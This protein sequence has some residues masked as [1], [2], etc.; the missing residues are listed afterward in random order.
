MSKCCPPAI[1][2]FM[3]RETCLAGNSDCFDKGQSCLHRSLWGCS[4]FLIAICPLT[5][6]LI[7]LPSQIPVFPSEFPSLPGEAA[8]RDW[9]GP[10]FSFIPVAIISLQNASIFCS[11]K[12][13]VSIEAGKAQLVKALLL[14][15]MKSV[16]FAFVRAL[17]RLG[18]CKS[19]EC[20]KER[21]EDR[22]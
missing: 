14:H 16:A 7:I 13:L 17:V 22:L 21:L 2:F 5:G 6:V 1:N 12:H 8:A 11:P 18:D 9:A 4:K 19:Q 15:K 3:N 10:N 20:L